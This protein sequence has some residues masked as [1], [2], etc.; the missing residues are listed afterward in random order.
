MNMILKKKLAQTKGR[1]GFTLVEVIV[2]LVI[3]AIL[4]AIAIPA[5]T[6]YIDK[7]EDKEYIAQARNAVVAI[8]ATLNDL[9]AQGTLGVGLTEAN[10][11]SIGFNTSI[12]GTDFLT[13]G[14]HNADASNFKSFSVGT[15]SRINYFHEFTG[16]PPIPD[17]AYTVYYK[18]A[19]ELMG[20]PYPEYTSDPGAWELFYWAPRKD[21]SGNPTSYT[22]CNA[23][24]FIYAYFPEGKYTGN[25][26]VFVT[27]GLEGFEAYKDKGWGKFMNAPLTPGQGV[28]SY[29]PDTGYQVFYDKSPSGPLG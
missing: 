10:L 23:P 26:V 13:A 25:P 11:T 3:L 22:I 20:V 19:A 29:N 6:G 24:A 4:A 16:A 18:M 14:A 28:I 7:A 21:G 8:R 9:Y 1:K 17:K 2:V 27:Y 5:L 12:I 15:C